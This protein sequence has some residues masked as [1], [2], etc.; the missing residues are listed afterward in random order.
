MKVCY[1][2]NR[3]VGYVVTKSGLKTRV[4]E[5]ILRQEFFDRYVHK[6]ISVLHYCTSVGALMHS[7]RPFA[8]RGCFVSLVGLIAV[9]LSSFLSVNR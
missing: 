3:L 8:D 1:S 2:L 5:R 7:F 4:S 6:Y 9:I